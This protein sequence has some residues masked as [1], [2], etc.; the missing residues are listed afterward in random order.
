MDKKNHYDQKE[1]YMINEKCME[2]KSVYDENGNEC[3]KVR[4]SEQTFI[5]RKSPEQ[6][7]DYSLNCIGFDLKGALKAA[8]LLLHLDKKYMLPVLINHVHEIV[9]FPT[10][11]PKNHKNIWLNP[12]HIKRTF[13]KQK[14]TIIHF[15]NGE[16]TIIEKKLIYF[17]NHF[18]TAKQYLE[19]II[20]NAKNP[21]LLPYDPDLFR[22]RR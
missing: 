6:I 9:L 17:N 15:S 19:N 2:L 8:K 12:K 21:R 7:I 13:P 14:Q 3:T 11:S 5:V 18:Q 22:K 20:E 16:T 1:K 10:H 4:E